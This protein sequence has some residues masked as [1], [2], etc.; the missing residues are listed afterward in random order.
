VAETKM[1]ICKYFCKVYRD[2]K[3]GPK[4]QVETCLVQFALKRYRESETIQSLV[5]IKKQ[6]KEL[7]MQ[8]QKVLKNLKK[9]K[10]FT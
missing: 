3:N 5:A 4:K 9:C 6:M 8:K 2:L 7:E 1:V 10:N